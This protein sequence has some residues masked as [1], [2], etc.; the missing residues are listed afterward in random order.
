MKILIQLLLGLS[1]IS[2]IWLVTLVVKNWPSSIVIIQ[3]VTS[4]CS[5]TSVTFLLGLN[6]Y[7]LHR[8]LRAQD[9]QCAQL[10]IFVTEHIS[11]M[12]AP[13]GVNRS[14]A[15]TQQISVL[16]RTVVLCWYGMLFSIV[17]QCVAWRRNKK[18]IQKRY[19]A[20]LRV[21]GTKQ[22]LGHRTYP[23]HP[24]G[25]WEVFLSE[26]KL[27]SEERSTSETELL[28]GTEALLLKGGLCSE[29]GDGGVLCSLQWVYLMAGA[30]AHR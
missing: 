11:V 20:V 15:R 29:K 17:A 5:E 28:A 7:H 14:K 22:C 3:I 18:G 30:S 12:K 27:N 10:G 25:F 4:Q 2:E 21:E 1:P 8:A 23:Q 19:R 16:G 26:R 9:R 24:I 13:S 6:K